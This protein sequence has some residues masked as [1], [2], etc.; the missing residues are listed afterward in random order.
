MTSSA[1]QPR[2]RRTQQQ[3]SDATTHELLAAARTL[4][5]RDGYAATSLEAICA[6]AHSTKGAL[7]HHF[8]GKE[9]LF[10]AVYER[11]QQR[12]S[13][14]IAET[15]ARYDDPWEGLYQ[16][17]KAFLT[18]SME[19]GVQR[20]TLIDAPGAIGWTAMR[21]MRADCRRNLV[22]GLRRALGPDARCEIESLASI[23]YGALCESAV[24]LAH[25]AEP[26]A[27]L[28]AT[29]AQLRILFDG[30]APPPHSVLRP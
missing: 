24:A 16:G 8:R 30:F 22:Y 6:E 13:A 18:G 7:Y 5:A 28:D 9:S 21:E 10:R 4:F 20:I 26:A 23:L 17:L 11:E 29:L 19:P 27:L 14:N 3:R 12:L 2:G 25:C 1:T 15:Y